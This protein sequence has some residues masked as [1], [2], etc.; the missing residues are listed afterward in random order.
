MTKHKQEWPKVSWKQK[1]N[2]QWIITAVCIY[3]KLLWWMLK[4][5]L[6][7]LGCD[8]D[9]EGQVTHT[10]VH[11][12]R[13]SS[14][15]RRSSGLF[16]TGSQD[17][18]SH[19]GSTGDWQRKCYLIPRCSSP[20][21]GQSALSQRYLYWA[22]QRGKNSATT[23]NVSHCKIY[24]LEVKLKL[25][26]AYIH[27]WHKKP[28]TRKW[29]AVITLPE[30]IMRKHPLH[31]F[32]VRFSWFLSLLFFSMLS[33]GNFHSWTRGKNVTPS[34]LWACQP[35]EKQP[36]KWETKHIPNNLT[37]VSVCTTEL[38]EMNISDWT[39]KMYL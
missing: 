11:S 7:T 19:Q 13:C 33:Q 21:S 32:L 17:R 28:S 20:S 2:S 18:C 5:S 1:S 4:F 29:Q 23:L 25:K 38:S 9:K 22:E 26:R 10:R 14:L 15:S 3:C 35:P 31:G 24:N 8:D 39:P 30:Y 36:P 16:H 6:R 27:I 37:T 34:L 12:S